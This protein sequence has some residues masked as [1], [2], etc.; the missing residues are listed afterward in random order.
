MWRGKIA[1]Y[2]LP[3][4][5][6]KANGTHG[7]QAFDRDKEEGHATRDHFQWQGCIKHGRIKG[8][9]LGNRFTIGEHW[10]KSGERLTHLDQME[11]PFPHLKC[12][13]NYSHAFLKGNRRL[14]FSKLD[15]AL[16]SEYKGCSDRWM[17]RHG[18]FDRRGKEAYPVVMR[19]I[20]SREHEGTLREIQ[21]FGECLHRFRVQAARIGK[22]GQ[23]VPA[24]RLIG[25][26]IH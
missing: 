3:D 6:P 20:L 21:F 7:L 9:H 18:Q 12:D 4:I 25:K 17:T 22:D 2:T 24:E 19:S 14:W 11:L 16:M 13:R 5:Q 8:E 15:H 23:L 10:P 1:E 26:H